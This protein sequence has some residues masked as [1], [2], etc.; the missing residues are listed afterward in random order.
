MRLNKNTLLFYS[1]ALPIDRMSLRNYFNL[2][3]KQ[4]EFAYFL[5]AA[6]DSLDNISLTTLGFGP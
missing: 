4:T 6:F 1:L 5:R 3:F 2:F